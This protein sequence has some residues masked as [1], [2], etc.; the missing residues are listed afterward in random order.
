MLIHGRGSDLFTALYAYS[1]WSTSLTDIHISPELLSSVIHIRTGS[2]L[3]YPVRKLIGVINSIQQVLLLNF[4]SNR[5]DW[6]MMFEQWSL[7]NEWFYSLKVLA[8]FRSKYLVD[9]ST[10]DIQILCLTG[11]T[12]N[13]ASMKAT[14]FTLSVEINKSLPNS[15]SALKQC[16]R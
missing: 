9:L 7:E 13:C 6:K 5:E 3:L 16:I 12:V 1:R 4:L 11:V 8:H 10:Y 14:Y 2:G 15:I